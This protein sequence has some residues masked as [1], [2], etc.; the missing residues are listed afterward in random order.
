MKS[1]LKVQGFQSP[2][3]GGLELLSPSET[4]LSL[5]PSSAGGNA[6]SNARLTALDVSLLPDLSL[7]LPHYF[8]IFQ[9][10]QAYSFLV[11]FLQLSAVWSSLALLE[12]KAPVLVDCLSLLTSLNLEWLLGK[13]NK[14]LAWT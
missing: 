6:A 5:S 2:S 14:S 1:N 8:V 12:I 7:A 9:C 4:L 11:Q 10:L 13:S 3:L